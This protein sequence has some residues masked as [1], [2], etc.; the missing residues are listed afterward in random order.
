MFNFVCKFSGGNKGQFLTNL[1]AYVR[2][3]APSATMAPGFY[4]IISADCKGADQKLLTRM[5]CLKTGLLHGFN[6]EA[7]ARSVIS[8]KDCKAEHAMRKLREVLKDHA[9][10]HVV[11]HAIEKCDV[12][13]I[14]AIL[15]RS[16]ITEAKTPEAAVYMTLI[17]VR[18]MLNIDINLKEFDKHKP[19]PN[20]KK[21]KKTIK[22]EK[23]TFA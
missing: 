5:G 1:E 17:E 12:N 11:Q 20:E 16:D 22:D 3:V 21:D 15:C 23:K 13:I 4:D 14:G 8:D 19:K 9:S 18:D 6:N 2:A 10:D 7:Q